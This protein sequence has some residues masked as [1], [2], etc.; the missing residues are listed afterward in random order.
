MEKMIETN[1]NKRNMDEQIGLAAGMASGSEREELK[2]LRTRNSKVFAGKDHTMTARIFFEPVHDPDGKGGWTERSD[3]LVPVDSEGKTP[4]AGPGTATGTDSDA[5]VPDNSQMATVA[6]FENRK[7]TWKAAFP[8]KQG[9]KN[10][11]ALSSGSHAISWCLAESGDVD[12]NM[13]GNDEVI[14]KGI[15]PGVDLHSRVLGDSVKEDLVLAGP[16]AAADLLYRYKMDAGLHAVQ[17]GKAVAFED[18]EGNTV[19]RV[20]APFM[21]D[22]S[23]ARSSGVRMVL[24]APADK[25]DTKAEER[26]LRRALPVPRGVR[27]HLYV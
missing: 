6:G 4:A 1:G 13:Q 20:A 8:K 11:T 19:F 2:E 7:G 10:E 18:S 26:V 16:E 12:G 24:E 9:G 15:L 3:A 5:D 22:S 21:K 23:S 27:A 14:Y 25:K 17:E